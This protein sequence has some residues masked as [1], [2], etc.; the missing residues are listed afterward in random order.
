MHARRNNLP[1]ADHPRTRSPIQL[2]HDLGSLTQHVRELLLKPLEEATC[3]ASESSERAASRR[4]RASTISRFIAASCRRSTSS[5]GLIMVAA[6]ASELSLSGRALGNAVRQL[7]DPHTV[8]HSRGHLEVSIAPV[9]DGDHAWVYRGCRSGQVGLYPGI[10][11]GSGCPALRAHAR[12]QSGPIGLQSGPEPLQ[13]G[14]GAGQREF[15]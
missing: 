7:I 8:L 13:S 4:L 10:G 9:R 12:A 14:S 3:W 1:A 5:S 6:H 11:E 15:P 2:A